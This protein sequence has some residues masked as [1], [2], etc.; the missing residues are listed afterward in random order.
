MG[1]F[2]STAAAKAAAKATPCGETSNFFSLA[3]KE[4][5]TPC[6]RTSDVLWLHIYIYAYARRWH[7]PRCPAT[8]SPNPLASVSL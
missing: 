4:F 7:G 5:L 6:I 3:C 8:R 2:G 1:P